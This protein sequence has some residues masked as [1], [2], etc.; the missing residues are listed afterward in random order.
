MD[1]T[2]SDRPRASTPFVSARIE[3]DRHPAVYPRRMITLYYTPGACSLAAHILLEETGLDFELAKVSLSSGE[4]HNPAF[5]SLNPHGRVP[6]LVTGEDAITES[7]AI[8]TWIATKSGR[9]DLLGS[10]ALSRARVY[11]RLSFFSGSVHVAYAQTLRPGRFSGDAAA[12]DLIVRGGREVFSR[13]IAE[14]EAMISGREWMVGESFT[15]A[16]LYPLIF[17]PWAARLGIDLALY[18]EWKR[19]AERM[20]ELPSVSRAMATEA[21]MSR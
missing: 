8:L 2:R 6:V 17:R 5:L 15:A 14:I 4:Q 9:T 19:H 20:V 10:D 18:P 13:Q 7:T 1:E 11:E 16:D 21:Q 12:H 3:P